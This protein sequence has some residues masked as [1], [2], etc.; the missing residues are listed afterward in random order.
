M[1]ARTKVKDGGLSTNHNKVLG[2]EAAQGP[3]VR[4]GV[5]AGQLCDNHNEAL[6]GDAGK[7]EGLKVRTDVRAGG[8]A[9]HNEALARDTGMVKARR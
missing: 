9:Q 5:E 6:A 2:R 1:K 4:T 7:A 3:E 8:L